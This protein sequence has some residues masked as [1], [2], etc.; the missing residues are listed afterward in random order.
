MPFCSLEMTPS[1]SKKN[2]AFTFHMDCFLSLFFVKKEKRTPFIIY[3]MVRETEKWSE[4]LLRA[5]FSKAQQIPSKKG[6]FCEQG[7]KR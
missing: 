7:E 3:W 5:F 4:S 1:D 2:H 6:S